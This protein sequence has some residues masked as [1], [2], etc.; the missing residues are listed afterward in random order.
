MTNTS[1]MTKAGFKFPGVE[2]SY[3][4]TWPGAIGSIAI[5]MMLAFIAYIF[6]TELSDEVQNSI[7]DNIGVNKSTD[8]S[9]VE[10]IKMK[11]L[12]EV[13]NAQ[14]I[15][16]S[17]RVKALREG[18]K[19]NIDI[20][21][22]EAEIEDVLKI[23]DK[24]K[25]EKVDSI[26]IEQVIDELAK[27]PVHVDLVSYLNKKRHWYTGNRYWVTFQRIL[28]DNKNKDL[29]DY[30]ENNIMKSIYELIDADIMTV[31]SNSNPIMFGLKD[32]ENLREFISI[33]NK[34]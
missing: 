29:S 16:I 4:V 5:C 2:F 14:L 20:P 3:P 19:D 31:K 12:L 28:N 7:I 22:Y 13:K 33:I 1:E 11:K 34:K 27:K 10:S 23:T 25:L 17:N 32:G 6:S 9:Y 24:A 18:L 30:D 8:G 21:N 15:E 26:H